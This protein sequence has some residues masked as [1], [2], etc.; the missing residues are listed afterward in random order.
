MKKIGLISLGCDKNR[1]DSE[2]LLGNAVCNKFKVVN[3]PMDAD[4]LIINTCAFIE[5]ARQE[6]I[7]AIFDMV[8]VKNATGSKIIVTGCLAQRYPQQLF[9]EIPEIDAVVGASFYSDFATMCDKVLSGER[10]V[11]VN[12]QL[13]GVEHGSRLLTTPSDYAYLRIADGCDNFCTYCS[14]PFIRGRYRSRTKEELQKEAVSLVENGVKEIILVAQDVTNYGVDIY[15]KSEIVDLIRILSQIDALQSIR[16]LYCYPERITDQLIAEI[17]NNPKIVK[18]IDMPLQHV[19]DDVL[20]RM[21]RK[22]TYNQIVDVIQKLRNNVKNI[23]LRTTFICGFPAETQQAHDKVKEFLKTYKFTN[24][25]FFAYS[26][27]EGTAAFSMHQQIDDAKKV[28]WVQD[29][30][31]TQNKISREFNQK[32]LG[33]PLNVIIDGFL[34]VQDDGKNL[35]ESRAYFM[36]PQIDGKVY[37]TTTKNLKVGQNVDVLVTDYNDYD[38]MGVLSDESA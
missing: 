35:Y 5:S 22:S 24:V 20:K 30:A 28:E 16:L 7:E 4:V 32:L 15:G 34:G 12:G 31:E 18:Y 23:A 1:V 37:L 33:Q 13:K 26:K 38:L 3:N 21:N 2:I 36:A 29:L 25:G 10:F 27:E 14:I 17:A 6:A 9:E 8:N 11:E 19:D